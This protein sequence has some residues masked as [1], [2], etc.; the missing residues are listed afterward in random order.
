MQTKR[1]VLYKTIFLASL[2]GAG[3]VSA[4]VVVYCT[5]SVRQSTQALEMLR[6][7]E[8]RLQVVSGQYRLE[9]SSYAEYS[10]IETEAKKKLNMIN[11]NPSD[12]ILVYRK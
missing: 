10:R 1:T 9:Q 11:P 8:A 6:Q 12:I 5:Y 7:E 3:F 4:L 2:W